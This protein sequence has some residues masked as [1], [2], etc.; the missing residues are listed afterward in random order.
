MKK[1]VLEKY[2]ENFLLKE[3]RGRLKV[4]D[5]LTRLVLDINFHLKCL[6]KKVWFG[7]FQDW[8]KRSVSNLDNNLESQKNT[9]EE[10]QDIFNRTKI[11]GDDF[12]NIY[13][14]RTSE[15]DSIKYKI[16]L[17]DKDSLSSSV[18]GGFDFYNGTEKLRQRIE[19]RHFACLDLEFNKKMSIR[20]FICDA[21][22][23]KGYNAYVLKPGVHFFHPLTGLPSFETHI[24]FSK[25]FGMEEQYFKDES[26][27]RKFA[28]S[29][30]TDISRTARHELMHVFQLMNSTSS[31]SKKKKIDFGLP[32]K[33]KD[34]ARYDEK[35]KN[36]LIVKALNNP[37]LNFEEEMGNIKHKQWYLKDAEF[38]PILSDEINKFRTIFQNSKE[39]IGNTSIKM[40][41]KK[42][43]VVR[44]FKE[45]DR[46]KYKKFVKE[47]YNEIMN[48]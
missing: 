42:S 44:V 27:A 36:N 17:L 28:V 47:F 43:Q 26:E 48:K 37:N 15:L 20:L 40:F 38:Y 45:Y 34:P 31:K 6:N 25:S 22:S 41:L 13:G 30:N 7:D 39:L 35:I 8:V 14:G 23:N 24:F 32:L 46:K 19:G 18:P 5:K 10:I 16:T 4:S 29:L 33:E 9:D 3:V 21:P 11:M 2:I 12:F 1:I